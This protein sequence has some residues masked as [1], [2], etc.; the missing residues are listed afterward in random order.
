MG[1]PVY[2]PMLAT[3]S[4]EVTV[5]PGW[6]HEVKWDGVR[7][8]FAGDG[9]IHSRNGNRID[10]S[11]PE[12]AGAVPPGSV[13]DGEIVAFDDDGRPSFQAL[14]ARMHVRDPRPRLVTATPVTFMA[15][16]LLHDDEPLI[17]LPLEARR[18]R[19]ERLELTPPLMLADVHDDARALFAAVVEHDLEGIV[20]KRSGSVY[21]PG[22]R[23][24]D[25]R[26]TANRKT[27]EALVVGALAGTGA[28]TS[29][30]GS[31][32]LAVWTDEG[33]LRYV[34]SV[35][36]GFDQA[37]LTAV[38]RAILDMATDRPDDMKD[39]DAVP[40]PIRWVVPSL[41]AVVEY[42]AWTDDGRLRAP[43]FKGFS[44]TPP[45]EITWAREGPA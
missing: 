30:F 6:V 23:S 16:D 18:S 41:V 9:T 1:L 40:G 42:A 17:H 28:R 25:W 37:T 20:S 10:S 31:L 43:V 33:R 44:A 15:F 5:E 39:V 7:A 2:Q 27:C 4:S 34:G 12:L 36:S 26:K 21:R 38:N 14:Q 29:T 24:E 13:L 22:R 11:Y 35:G 19:L 45:G 8:I 3:R 32:A